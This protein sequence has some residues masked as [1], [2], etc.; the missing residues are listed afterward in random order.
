MLSTKQN[1]DRIV[2]VFM[3]VVSLVFWWQLRSI[4]AGLD[5]IFPRF[6]IACLVGL[7][8]LLLV[9]SV[10]KPEFAELLAIQSKSRVVAGAAASVAWVVFL[11]ILGFAITSVLVFSAL[12]WLLADRSK[13]NVS[14]AIVSLLVAVAIVAAVYLVFAGFLEVPLP[15]GT[16]F[17]T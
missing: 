8:L 3:L 7:S 17:Q 14:T 6:I 4:S 12:S 10:V 2:A 15:R 11:R 9:K 1:T 13:R 5:I 16:L